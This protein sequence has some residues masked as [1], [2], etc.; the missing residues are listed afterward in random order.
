MNLV[1]GSWL[2]SLGPL[3]FLGKC[4]IK[5]KLALAAS[6]SNGVTGSQNVAT[7]D[8]AYPF[9]LPLPRLSA[10]SS[11]AA[12]ET[13]W[14]SANLTSVSKVGSRSPDSEY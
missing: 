4:Q 1:L 12:R 13:A 6:K 9:T 11:N 5:H 8:M 7:F 2:W 14:P 10:G 3:R